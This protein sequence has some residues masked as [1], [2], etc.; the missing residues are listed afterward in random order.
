MGSNKARFNLSRF[1]GFSVDSEHDDLPEEQGIPYVALGRLVHRHTEQT[2]QEDSRALSEML[3]GKNFSLAPQWWH[4]APAA[5]IV[6]DEFKEYSAHQEMLIPIAPGWGY[7]VVEE[8]KPEFL[9]IETKAFESGA[10]A[11]ALSPGGEHLFDEISLL[12][13]LARAHFVTVILIDNGM[14][15]IRPP[16]SFTLASSL[17]R[18]RRAVPNSLKSPASVDP[19]SPTL[20]PVLSHLCEYLQQERR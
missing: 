8:I 14:L 17:S 19:Y 1:F 6:S 7:H 11:H 2:V 13:N 4:Q 15:D 20:S 5:G 9:V 12:S 18:L 10:W 16:R 3:F